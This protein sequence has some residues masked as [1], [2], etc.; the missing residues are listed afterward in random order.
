MPAQRSASWAI[1]RGT[2]VYVQLQQE[3]SSK[4]GEV[5][6]ARSKFRLCMTV[7]ILC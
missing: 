2:V 3:E 4:E 6:G 7:H 5:H 1:G